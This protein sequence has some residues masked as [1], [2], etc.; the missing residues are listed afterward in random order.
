MQNFEINYPSVHLFESFPHQKIDTFVLPTNKALYRSHNANYGWLFYDE[1]DGGRFNGY[2]S[3]TL[4]DELKDYNFIAFGGCYIAATLEGALSESIFRN[5]HMS[6]NDFIEYNLL[7]N[8]R[9]TEIVIPDGTDL[10]LVDMTSQKTR[11]QLGLDIQIFS[12]PN[13]EVCF[14]WAH[15]IYAK[16]YDGIRYRSRNSE[17]ECYVIFPTDKL[18]I[19]FGE[20][21]GLLNSERFLVE[22]DAFAERL[23]FVVERQ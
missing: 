22:I 15:L 7:K 21:I 10:I 12:T 5:I 4:P 23:G 6:K 18:D 11:T 13:Y 8:R 3:N 17:H 9:M 19:D 16:G 1:A 20:S 2:V 14:G